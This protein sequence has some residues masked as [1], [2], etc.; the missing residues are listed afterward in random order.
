M[1]KPLLPTRLHVSAVLALLTVAFAAPAQA[2][3]RPRPVNDA[4]TGETFHI[5]ADASFW[6]PSAEMTIESE[7]LGI[8]GSKIDLEKDLGI[9]DA[10]VRA[11]SL[12]LRP[13]RSHH[14]R[15]QYIPISYEGNASVA[16]DFV[17][18]GI[19]YPANVPVNSSLDWKTY[20]FGYQYDFIVKNRGFAG[21]ILEAKYTDVRAELDSPF[22]REFAHAR[23][24]IPALGGIVR[25]Y[26]APNVSITGELTGVTDAW[27][28]DSVKAGNQAHYFDI[29]VYGTINFTDNIGAK[30]GYRSLD[31]GYHIS[32]DTGSFV[33][34][35]I[36]F[37]AVLRY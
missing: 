29:D 12:Q 7:G 15:F 8:A 36:Y 18:N 27:V 1:Q 6:S 16:H 19:R 25:G 21:V 2:Q 34:K 30:A 22:A 32:D 37:G 31:L 35:G 28:P 26:V 11:L 9:G 4:A 33:L 3:Y 10:H 13:A 23:A 24:P 5:E 20:R 14:L 17:F